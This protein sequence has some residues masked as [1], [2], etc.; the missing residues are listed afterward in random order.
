M[1]VC[2]HIRAWSCLNSMVAIIDW[3]IS[4]SWNLII[5][6]SPLRIQKRSQVYST[7]SQLQTP[8]IWLTRTLDETFTYVFNHLADHHHP[9]ES[10]MH[11]AY[12][13]NS[14]IWYTMLANSRKPRVH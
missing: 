10:C 6:Y 12:A 4:M 9:H 1:Y 14:Q 8:W 3:S 11:N 7:N 13:Y 5:N 2:M